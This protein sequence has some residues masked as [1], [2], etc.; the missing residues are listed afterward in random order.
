MSDQFTEVTQTSWLG[1]LGGSFVAMIFGIVLFF[2]SFFLLYWNEGRAVLAFDTLNAGARM[3][4]SVPETAVDPANQGHLVHVTGTAAVNRA[5]TDPTFRVSLAGAIRLKRDVLMYQWEQTEHSETHKNVGG[6][7][8]TTT[9]YSYNKTWSATPID[10]TKF[11]HPEGHSNPT[12]SLRS[13]VFDADTVKLGAFRMDTSLVQKLSTYEKLAPPD[14]AA[15]ANSSFRSEGEEY[16]RGA[17]PDQ[18]TIGDLRVSFEVIK[19]QPVSVVAAQVGSTLAPFTAPNGQ[20]IELVD[21][22]TRDAGAMFQEAKS[23]AAMWTW[24]LR[25]V[26]FVMMVI[27]ITLMSSPL[28]WLAS[29][30]PILGDLIGAGA[31]LVGLVLSI[32]LTLLTI[33]IAWIVHRPLLGIGLIVAGAVLAVGL[34]LML[35][36]RRAQSTVTHA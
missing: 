8:T 28:S 17:S 13:A 30:L 24:I 36:Q 2:G 4:V 34:H 21:L 11:K 1:R 5:A 10:S 14:I 16:Y 19:A 27:G 18:P 7:E 6:S 20:T 3:V 32:P 31:F 23:E 15:G 35:R 26:G 9:T 33:A 12:M 25:G 22:G 29:V